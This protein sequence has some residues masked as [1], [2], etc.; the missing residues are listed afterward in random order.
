MKK[1]V[2]RRLLAVLAATA[3]LLSG[4]AQ[5]GG[6]GALT[7]SAWSGYERFFAL[8]GETYPEIPIERS[9]YE[10]GNRTGYSWVQMRA[11][12]IPDIFV[13]SQI[14][15]E[16]LAKERLADLSGYDF[17]NR[18]TTSVLDQVAVDG[19]IYLLPVN[20]G[21][22]GIF[23]N[24]TLME[25]HGWQVPQNFAELEALCGEIRE[26]GLIP[27]VLGTQLTGNAFSTVF[28][29]AKTDWL[30]TPEGVTWES[31]F[32]SGE[33]DAAGMWEGT[34]DYVQRYMDLG[35]FTTDPEDRNN[36]DVF[37]DYLGNR[38]A[39][40]CTAVM[41]LSITEIPETGDK[42][43]MMPFISEDG[44][45]NIYMYNP[46]SYI[47]ISRR[48][49]EPGNE[50][51]LQ[52]AVQLLSL[53]YSPEGQETFLTEETPCVLSVLESDVLSPDA[54]VYDA[55]RAMREGRA[56]PMTYE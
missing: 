25:E 15:D 53:L 14:L 45:K 43:G 44:S 36:P 2:R 48:L 22:Y 4:C 32:L 3:A 21:M 28:N 20:Y 5:G 6:G 54:L 49:T 55:Q 38:K 56:F 50:E 42:I 33:A 10:G 12:D 35:M 16:T 40:F 31:R 30:T 51:K 41:T 52:Q 39:V 8:A 7:C 19:G 13:T 24:Q 29:L 9:P 47:G 18:F 17:I 46:T 27:G 23:Y 26:A 34:M 1:T 11:D 37:L